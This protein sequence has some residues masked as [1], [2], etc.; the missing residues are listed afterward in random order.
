TDNIAVK[1]E[2][3]RNNNFPQISIDVL[4]VGH[5]G[6]KN[7]TDPSFVIHLTPHYALISVGESNTYGHPAQEVIKSLEE[8]NIS[9]MRTD[10]QGAIIYRY[11]DNNG[12]FMEYSP[13]NGNRKPLRINKKETS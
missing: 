5:H 9:I 6:S 3:E 12:T 2:K 1:T 7:S 11:K 10:Q 8:A 4:K 13:Y